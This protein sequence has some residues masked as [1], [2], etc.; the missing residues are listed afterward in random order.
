M[1]GA[2]D[3]TPSDIKRL[4]AFSGNQCAKPGCTRNVIG[5]DDLTVVGKICHI[6]AASKNGPRYDSKMTDEQRRGYD[7]LILLCDEHHSIID[8]KENETQYPPELLKK[9]K[10]AHFEEYKY[11]ER[12]INEDL[13][14][15]A[16]NQLVQNN[17]GIVNQISVK[18]DNQTIK[19]QNTVNH[20]ST[21]H[22][23]VQEATVVKE[24]FDNAAQLAK[25]INFERKKD[26]GKLVETLNKIKINFP[27]IQINEVRQ[28]FTNSFSRKNSIEKY[29]SSLDSDLQQDLES[30]IFAKYSELKRSLEGV[31]LLSSLFS[32]Y[33]PEAKKKDPT[34][35]NMAQAYVLLF[36]EDCTIFEKTEKEKNT[37]R[38]LFDDL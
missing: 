20:Y 28:Y 38:D 7:N 3:Y 8:N 17:S 23:E 6:A 26:D 22:M 5:E 29:M 13:V 25:E 32:F 11:K 35:T 4:F 36:F 33:I 30:Q 9:W 14:N 2:R 37:Q 1:A 10:H 27:D 31:E 21:Q 19:I 15:G 12:E 18:G 34:Y 16:I 24:I